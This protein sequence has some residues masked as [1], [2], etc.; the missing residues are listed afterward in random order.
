MRSCSLWAPLTTSTTAVSPSQYRFAWALNNSRLDT[1]VPFQLRIISSGCNPAC[2]AGKPTTTEWTTTMQSLLPLL[3]S[4]IRICTPKRGGAPST[5]CS[6]RSLRVR[7]T[8][9]F[10]CNERFPFWLANFACWDNFAPTLT[11]LTMERACVFLVPSDAPGAFFAG[12]IVPPCCL[13]IV[14]VVAAPNFGL[15]SRGATIF[16]ITLIA[17]VAFC[18]GVGLGT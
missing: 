11:A 3:S 1:R 2:S 14:V 8:P 9:L 6:T 13:G 4:S 10:D 5:G 7:G 17:L 18:L 15:D 12:G 16:C